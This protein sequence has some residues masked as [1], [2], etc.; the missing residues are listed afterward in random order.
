MLAEQGLLGIAFPEEDGGQGG[1][2]IV[3]ESVQKCG[4][5][6]GRRSG[7]DSLVRRPSSAT[8][9]AIERSEANH[10]LDH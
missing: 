4:R 3:K 10:A 5:L 6:R 7:F 9:A 8:L 2:L 1:T